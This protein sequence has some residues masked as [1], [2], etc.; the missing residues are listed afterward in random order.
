MPKDGIQMPE[1]EGDRQDNP[2]VNGDFS[3]LSP[4]EEKTLWQKYRTRCLER[5]FVLSDPA[6][7]PA[8]LLLIAD[9]CKWL[10][11]PKKNTERDEHD[12]PVE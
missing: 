6:P 11:K 5:W 10:F 2:V 8:E 9:T 7:L 3:I 12:K 1:H 4:W